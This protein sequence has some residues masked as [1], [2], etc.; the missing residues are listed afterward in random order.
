MNEGIPA[1][2]SAMAQGTFAALLAAMELKGKCK[3]E[4]CKIM[5]KIGAE[6]KDKFKV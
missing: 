5:R 3:C 1:P 4:T 2:D 6:V